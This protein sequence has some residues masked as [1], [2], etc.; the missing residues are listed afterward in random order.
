MSQLCAKAISNK[1]LNCLP[2]DAQVDKNRLMQSVITNFKTLSFYF[3]GQ[4]L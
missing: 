3:A 1:T 4:L 2:L